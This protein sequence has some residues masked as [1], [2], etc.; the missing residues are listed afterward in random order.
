MSHKQLVF[1]DSLEV[2]ESERSIW[3]W[4]LLVLKYVVASISLAVVYYAIFGLLVSTDAEKKLIRENRLYEKSYRDMVSRQKLVS[5]AVE[6]LQLKDD[7]I[8]EEIF[9]AKA[10]SLKSLNGDDILSGLDTIPDRAMVEYAYS[11]SLKLEEVASSVDDKFN[12][13]LSM[14]DKGSR[15]IPPISLPLKGVSYAQVGASVGSR[16]NPFLKVESQHNGVDLIAPQGDPVYST[17]DGVV[18]SLTNSRKGQGNIVEITHS[19]GYVTRYA[20]LADVMVY[21]GQR[22]RRGQKIASVGISGN[23][24]A[25]HLHYE[26]L[27]DGVYLDPVD[28]FF[29]SV[30]PQEYAQMKFMSSRT[31]QSLD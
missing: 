3:Q 13:I 31:K 5:E 29:A 24:F 16:I 12:R 26:L 11:K 8:Y 19:S 20:H 27:K 2:K 14:M 21:N 23:S 17:A 1:D 25:P 30:D 9:Q 18:T 22:V 28:F 15:S 7:Q 6:N 4:I 10:P